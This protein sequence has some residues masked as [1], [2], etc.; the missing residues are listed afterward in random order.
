MK[1]SI[2]R[3]TQRGAAVLGACSLLLAHPAAAERVALVGGTVHPVSAPPIENGTVLFDGDTIVAVGRS[4][5]V[6]SDARVQNV[7]GLHVYPAL[8]DAN[9]ALGLVEVNSVPGTVDVS[10]LG[11][12]NPN[13]RAEVAINPDSEILPVTRASGILVAMTAPRGGI[14]AGTAALIRLQGWTW[15]DMTIAAPVGLLVNWPNMRIDTDPDARPKDKQIEA[16]DEKLRLLHEAFAD[17][18]AYMKAVEAEGAAGIPKHDRDPRWEA[19]LPVLRGEVPVMVAANDILQLRAVLRWVEEERVRLV[20]LTGGSRGSDVWRIAEELAVRDIPV[21]LG[22]VHQLPRRRWEP[23]DTPFTV[24]LKL[25]EAGV[26][27]CFAY[28]AGTFS[29]AHARNLPYHAATAAAYGLP[30][31]EALRGVTQYAA[32][33]LGVAERFGT[34]EAGKEATLIVTDGDP[35]EI[36]TRVQRAFMAGV[37]LDLDNRHERLYEK[38]RNRPR[39]AAKQTTPA[40]TT[41]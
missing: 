14:I 5:Q 16:R 38:Y 41:R 6:P 7:R 13:V 28:G 23:Y 36:R 9:T 19:M 17:A 26:R 29:A 33:I 37:E 20:L 10:E 39:P 11:D 1:H 22:G 2:T 27:F 34:L 4:V 25:H 3:S 12:I 31:L 30:K 21:I 15:E 24:A 18:R 32:E 8:I 40:I 35:L